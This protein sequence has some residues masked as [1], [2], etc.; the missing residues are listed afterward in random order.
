MKHVIWWWIAQVKVNRAA[1]AL[2]QTPKAADE[3]I[4]Y[5]GAPLSPSL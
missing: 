3:A 4:S 5:S 2:K 1:A